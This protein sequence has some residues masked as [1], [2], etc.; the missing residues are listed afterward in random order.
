MMTALPSLTP[1]DLAP[2]LLLGDGVTL[3]DGVEIGANVVLRDGVNVGRGA[4]IDDGAVLGRVPALGRRSRTPA[5]PPGATIVEEGA[6]VCPYAVIDAGV[7]VGRHAFV[8]DRT[9]LRAG[10]RLHTD[11]SIGGAS[12]LGRGVEVGE[13]ARTQNG[14]M[15]GPEASIEPDVFLGPGV[16]LLTGRLM[17]G[18]ARKPPPVLRRGCQLGAGALVMP[19]VEIGEGAVVG[20]GAVVLADVA[21]ATVVAGIPARAQLVEALA[22]EPDY[23]ADAG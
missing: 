14:C 9:S 18:S 11:A 7:H 12:F 16:Q 8:G 13:R 19:G 1:S 20:A 3:A 6:I 23:R 2:N 15:I 21:A 22:S 10:V 17:T 4:C 5:S